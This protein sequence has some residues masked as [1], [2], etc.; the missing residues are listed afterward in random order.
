[1][2]DRPA[3]R[4]V[5]EML[6]LAAV[7]SALAF[8]NVGAPAIAAVMLGGWALVGGVE[9]SASRRRAHYAAGLPPRWYVPHV[10]LPPAQPL[11]LAPAYPE[12]RPDE[13]ATW[14]ASAELRAE[15]LGE[16]P[17]AALGEDPATEDTQEA[18]PDPWLVVELPAVIEV[19]AAPEPEAE[20]EPE[21]EPKPEPV[22]IVAP[23]QPE[24]EPSVTTEQTQRVARYHVDPLAE[25]EKRRFGRRRELPSIEVPAGA[26]QP[27]PLPRAMQGART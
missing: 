17:V 24:P 2:P 5:L 1:V 26:P 6:Y 20:P 10:D 8:T 4:L 11:E 9:W 22:V 7:A 18:A 16:W 19:E 14:I 21:P 27:R 3:S 13:A 12:S 25:P 23:P 15:L